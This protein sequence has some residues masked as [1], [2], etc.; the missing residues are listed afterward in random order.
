MFN[1]EEYSDME[2]ILSLCGTVN[3]SKLNKLA[4]WADKASSM[5][6]DFDFSNIADNITD[7]VVI[8]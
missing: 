7:K 3:E 6:E 2:M 8:S 1:D 5:V 4:K